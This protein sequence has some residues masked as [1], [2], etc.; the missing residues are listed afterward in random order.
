M[1]IYTIYIFD[2]EG[3][4]S[5]RVARQY[6]I[7][8]SHRWTHDDRIYTRYSFHFT[9]S[10]IDTNNVTTVRADD[11]RRICRW[12]GKLM[13]M[14]TRG[15]H[16]RRY[17]LRRPLRRH[18]DALCPRYRRSYDFSQQLTNLGRFV[19]AVRRVFRHSS[20]LSFVRYR[21]A[22]PIALIAS[23]IVESVRFSCRRTRR[24]SR[25]ARYVPPIV[26]RYA[27]TSFRRSFLDRR[28]IDIN[29]RSDHMLRAR[30]TNSLRPDRTRFPTMSFT[31]DRASTISLSLSS[32]RTD[33]LSSIIVCCYSEN[34]DPTKTPLSR[35][36]ENSLRTSPLVFHLQDTENRVI[37]ELRYTPTLRDSMKHI[38]DTL[39]TLPRSCYRNT[40]RQKFKV[41]AFARVRETDINS[42]GRWPGGLLNHTPRSLFFSSDGVFSQDHPRD[43]KSRYCIRPTV[44]N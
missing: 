44:T 42:F 38:G 30:I 34:A 28:A 35:S 4:R 12:I 27:G 33:R 17:H 8:I 3:Y 15:N 18:V 25:Q 11:R 29:S 23:T 2:S 20:Q 32:T 6:D 9:W 31:D 43:R 16:S 5:H 37:T 24:D 22:P 40:P 41:S 1:Y 39:Q 7:I 21:R 36:N 19:D 14:K 26:P 10:C 13:A